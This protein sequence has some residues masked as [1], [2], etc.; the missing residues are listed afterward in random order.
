M[1][2][3]KANLNTTKVG[4]R[5][6]E[7]KLTMPTYE[8]GPDDRNP[9]LL[10]PRVNIIHPG[11][12]II[13]PYPMKEN[14]ANVRGEKTWRAI[15]VENPYLRITL[16][17][18]LGGRLLSAIDKTTGKEVFYRNHVVK[19]ARIGIRGAWISGG[20]E[21]NFPNGHTVTTVSPVDHAI[22]RNNDGS[23]TVIVSDIERVSRM[24]WSVALTL[25]PDKSYFETEIRLCNYTALPNRFWFWA[26]SAAP[27]S[28]GLQFITTATKVMTLTDV[29]SF[30]EHGGVDV[31]WDKNH[32]ASQ[33]MFS[34]NMGEDFAGWYNYD[35]DCGMIHFADRYKCRG[36][37]FYTWG[38]S[39]D[40]LIWTDLLTDTDGPYSEMQS[41]RLITQRVWEIMEPHTV[42]TWKEYWYPVKKMGSPVHANREAA[43]NLRSLH[44]RGEEAV[45][46]AIN[47]NSNY[48]NAKVLLKAGEDTIFEQVVNLSPKDPFSAKVP[49]PRERYMSEAVALI[50]H[51]MNG[52]QIVSYTKGVEPEVEK[53]IKGEIWIRPKEGETAEELYLAGLS[54]EKI[55]EA[56]RAT[57]LYRKA[58]KKDP[59]FSPANCAIGILHLRRGEYDSAQKAFE[60]ALDRDINCDK[61]RYY[62]GLVLKEK[63]QYK[64]SE[65]EFW[66]L[67]RSKTYGSLA[68]YF[69]GGL[70][71][72]KRDYGK[73]A[74]LFEQSASANPEN[75]KCLNF[76]AISLRKQ[77]KFEDANNL[78]LNVLK[79]DPT[80]FM[81]QCE[82]YFLEQER[83]GDADAEKDKLLKLLRN[84][85]QSYLEMATDYGEFG[86]Y[87]ESIQVLSLYLT[88]GNADPQNVY[89]LVH[90]YLGYN[91][92]KS[93][94]AGEAINHY[95]IGSQ[96]S[97][98][99]V[100]PHRLETI[101]VL[102][103]ALKHNPK[104]ARALY[105]LG[106][107][108]CAKDRPKE[109]IK[110]WEE[111][112]KLEG[113]FSVVH[114]N[115]GLA[116]WK[117]DNN[118]E[119]AMK[120][121]ERALECDPND[122]KLYY[123]LDQLYASAWQNDKRRY[124]IENV[125][126]QLAKHDMIA[127]RIACF[128]TDIGEF[129]KALQILK[130]TVFFPWEF[131]TE[132]RRLYVDANIGKGVKLINEG[133]Y[134]EAIQSFQEVMK[135][136]R[137]LGMGESV[138]KRNAEAFY[139]I[140]LT[141]EA[142]GDFQ[143]AISYWS[144]AASEKH[145]DWTDLRYYEALAL[146]K[147][148]K[149]R[150]AETILNG[151]IT[152][153]QE[154]LDGGRAAASNHYLLG[155]GY[156]G[157]GD[158]ESAKREFKKALEIDP[159][160]RRARWQLSRPKGQ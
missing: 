133:K 48:P 50:V 26:N 99:F 42:E 9:P 31:S 135:Y 88:E 85:V 125:P 70:S 146:Q 58:L 17:P 121:Y 5:V 150:E 157:K 136:P 95:T 103:Q 71:L 155:L 19:Y 142:M 96:A 73:A 2:E 67:E 101:K 25:F 38:N 113:D 41:G 112:A 37:K 128:Y 143:Q 44:E 117:V 87:K 52:E 130:E 139:F 60:A 51:D 119:L 56:N 43:L 138:N 65:E 102:N 151:L 39:D 152:F 123:E 145:A 100:F 68:T 144:R 91:Y 126:P 36:R 83:G 159:T 79:K 93:G 154:E 141:H 106:N 61:A 15:V 45:L 81:A 97:N 49:I 3:E 27:E 108:F 11:T 1:N 40:G 131:Y 115:L 89:P 69:L 80:N 124:L 53:E 90:Y 64:M 6:F 160:C 14:V 75:L 18:E 134:Q 137:N 46:I 34:L 110:L 140:G 22:R 62:L 111:S 147:L 156:K 24:K 76:L 63:E 149:S 29:W 12:S 28:K 98:E 104:D 72:L 10:I 148:G 16:L 47:V 13:Y 153:A 158:L 21:W 107:L 35:L 33:D 120:E 32:L 84:E 116:Y 132:S 8:L 66:M 77:G 127:E 118:L 55:G 57:E 30:P 4:V 92:E 78:L 114:R 86:L 54:Y 59:A 7:E 74:E 129:D 105:Y 122:Y 109:A 94:G 20:I 23:I 82:R